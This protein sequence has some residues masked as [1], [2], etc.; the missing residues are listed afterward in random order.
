MKIEQKWLSTENALPPL[1]SKAISI[2]K[3]K[4]HSIPV[5]LKDSDGILKAEAHFNFSLNGWV[6]PDEG[7]FIDVNERNFDWL[8]IEKDN[9]IHNEMYDI[10]LDDYGFLV[11]F[12][13]SSNFRYEITQGIGICK[14]MIGMKGDIFFLVEYAYQKHLSSLQNTSK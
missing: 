6:I 10:L 1:E 14:E 4:N 7:V 13:N 9:Y 2:N 12:S 5:L 8:K 3:N 11:D